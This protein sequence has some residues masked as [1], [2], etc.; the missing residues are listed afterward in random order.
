MPGAKQ[1]T[2]DGCGHKQ[3]FRKIDDHR[4]IDASRTSADWPGNPDRLQL[5]PSC[6]M[7]FV[8]P[9]LAELAAFPSQEAQGA[10]HDREKKARANN[11]RS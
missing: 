9:D 7:K 4:W 2:C 1:W 5:C 10:S 8:H 11:N 6:Q 3:A